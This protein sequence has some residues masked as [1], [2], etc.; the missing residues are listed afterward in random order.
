M[1]EFAIFFGFSTLGRERSSPG[2]KHSHTTP[3]TLIAIAGAKNASRQVKT[4][5]IADERR[6]APNVPHD[7]AEAMC[8]E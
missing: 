7:T 2:K 4:E 8:I 5:S 1:S 3:M 6:Y